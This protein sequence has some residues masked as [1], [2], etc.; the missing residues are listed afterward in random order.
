MPVQSVPDHL[1]RHPLPGPRKRPL[2]PFETGQPKVAYLQTHIIS[3]QNIL[4]FQ[5]SMDYAT[6][7]H[8][9]SGSGQLAQKVPGF[10]WAQAAAFVHQRGE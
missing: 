5:I 9:A 10:Y 7:V 2:G 4:C 8:K 6:Q 1:R 3:E